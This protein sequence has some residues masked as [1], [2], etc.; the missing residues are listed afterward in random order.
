MPR[1][2][3]FPWSRAQVN[4]REPHEFR[5]SGGFALGALAG[6]G[7]NDAQSYDVIR[8]VGPGSGCAVRGCG[9][10][11]EDAIHSPD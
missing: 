10:A 11:R 6:E 3:R 9:K 1:R 2:L 4:P 5:Q 7:G 8:P